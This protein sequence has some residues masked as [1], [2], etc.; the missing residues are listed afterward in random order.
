MKTRT[1]I[2]LEDEHYH[3]L[4]EQAL[5]EGAS[6]SCVVREMIGEAIQMRQRD[7]AAARVQEDPFDALLGKYASGHSDTS[8]RADEILYGREK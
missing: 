1:Q 2:L 8:A 4:K 6:I 5:R 3:Y 7:E